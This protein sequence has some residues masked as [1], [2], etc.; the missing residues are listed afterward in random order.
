MVSDYRH[1]DRY[2]DRHWLAWDLESRS[3]FIRRIRRRSIYSENRYSQILKTI[4]YT[5]N[6]D[7]DFVFMARKEEV[8]KLHQRQP[9]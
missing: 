2:I 9:N 1:V 4:I 5:Y 6:T 7:G 8:N 3:R